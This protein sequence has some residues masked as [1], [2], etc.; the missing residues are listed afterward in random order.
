MGRVKIAGITVER[1]NALSGG[2]GGGGSRFA[3]DALIQKD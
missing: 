3:A 1:L 2:G